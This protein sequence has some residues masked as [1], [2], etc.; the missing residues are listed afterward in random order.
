MKLTEQPLSKPK[1]SRQNAKFEEARALR[2]RLRETLR[3]DGELRREA[4]SALRDLAIP[5]AK[6]S[7]TNLTELVAALAWISGR[8]TGELEATK[9]AV[10]DEQKRNQADLDRL[11]GW[12]RLQDYLVAKN[13]AN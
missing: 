4:R 7:S 3:E 9:Q 13:W 1:R 10:E 6:G 11:T 2:K 5:S 12:P 8:L